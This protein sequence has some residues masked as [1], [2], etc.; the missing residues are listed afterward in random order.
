MAPK[1]RVKAILFEM[2]N[3]ENNTKAVEGAE[4]VS[5]E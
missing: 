1:L 3:M 4:I 5:G 2:Q